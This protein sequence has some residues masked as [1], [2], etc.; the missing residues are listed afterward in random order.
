MKEVEIA[1]RDEALRVRDAEVES[2]RRELDTMKAAWARKEEELA[3]AE[4]EKEQ[5]LSRVRF[6]ESGI[7]VLLQPAQDIM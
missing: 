1:Q 4:K 3:R 5:A 6:I 7:K 2:L